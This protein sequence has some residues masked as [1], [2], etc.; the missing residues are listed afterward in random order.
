MR[1]VSDSELLTRIRADLTAAM[2]DRDVVTTRTLRAV[3]AA[4][5]EAEKAGSAHVT[6]DEAE[7]EKVL[8]TQAK[9]RVEAAEAFDQGDRPEK[10]A[11]E[12]AE[13]AVLENYL[14][15]ALTD[16]ELV[17][18]IEETL[19][20]EGISGKA[21]MG[22]A[23]KA[24][25]A[26]VAGRAEGKTVANL[27]WSRS[28]SPRPSPRSLTWPGFANVLCDVSRF[29]DS[30]PNNGRVTPVRSWMD[31]VARLHVPAALAV[32]IALLAAA[33]GGDSGTATAGSAPTESPATAAAEASTPETEG[34]TDDG[35][36]PGDGAM[37]G[38]AVAEGDS[39]PAP[40]PPASPPASLP[41]EEA[42]AA[43]EQNIPNLAASDDVRDIEVVSV[44][45]G[46]VTTLREVATGDRPV[47]V[48][49]WAPH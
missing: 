47:L 43:A 8:A 27:V 13:L 21:D 40:V 24:V 23:M 34:D 45:D 42:A 4:I 20:A 44:F 29:C 31:R 41:P 28:A 36:D 46:S 6:L 9:R 18:L 19:A 39:S 14:P 16:D 2:K 26:K 3:I 22:R 17:A 30:I 37:A 25:N 32:A 12:R 1:S 15:K 33:C 7:V 38:D 11:D 48:W 5:Q 49:F 35:A 10:A